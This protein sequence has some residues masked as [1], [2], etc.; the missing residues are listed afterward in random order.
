MTCSNEGTDK[1]GRTLTYCMAGD[2]D[3]N[4]E[5]VRSGW[6]VAYGGLE[7]TY[8]RAESEAKDKHR[9]IWQG[10]FDQPQSWRDRNR[11]MQG[12]MTPDD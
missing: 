7:F 5:M 1:Y 2:T 6:A 4:G 3:L 12:G 8:W 10:R 11:L 9:G